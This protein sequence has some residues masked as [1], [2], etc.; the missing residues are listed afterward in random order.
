ML[1]LKRNDDRGDGPTI[2]ISQ[3]SNIVI[4]KIVYRYVVTITM[5][6]NKVYTE[7]YNDRRQA[8]DRVNYIRRRAD[9]SGRGECVVS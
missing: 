9:P 6:N 8:E 1:T 2:S 3:I 7:N 5:A 4:N